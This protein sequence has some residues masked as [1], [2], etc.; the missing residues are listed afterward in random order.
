MLPVAILFGTEYLT[1][2]LGWDAL[3]MFLTGIFI[4]VYYIMNRGKKGKKK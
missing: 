2:G 1:N 4:L 3:I